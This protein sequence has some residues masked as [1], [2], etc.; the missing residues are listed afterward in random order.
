[1]KYY[2]RFADDIIKDRLKSSGAVLIEGTKGCGKTETAKQLAKSVARFDIDAQVKLQMELNPELVLEGAVPRLLDEWQY[3]PEI[4]NYVRHFIDERKDK[5]QFILT[6]SASPDE[7]TKRHSGAGRFSI[8]KMRPMSFYERGWSSGEVSLLDLFKG[9]EPITKPI[10][11][12]LGQ[13]AE[14]I[15]I[16]GWPGLINEDVNTGLQFSKDYMSLIAEIDLSKVSNRNRD[17]YKVMRLLQSYARNISTPA[18]MSTLAKDIK[19]KDGDLDNATVSSYIDALEKLM[20]IEHLPAWNTHIRSAHLLRTSPK[21]HFA[22]PSMAVG[23]LGLSVDDLIKDLGYFTFL[24]E[25]LVIRDLRIYSQ[26]SGANVF[27]YRDSG[28]LEVD[29]IVEYPDGTW[30]AFEVKLG[31]GAV[32]EAASGLIAFSQKIDTSKIKPPSV[33]GVI[34]ANGFAHK[35]KDGVYVIPLSVLTA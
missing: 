4:W 7:K 9:I 12:E 34:T 33:L 10:D 27:Y 32:E 25:S 19:G 6:G 2:K 5:G 20:A 1:M 31:I 14:Q 22:D 17:P 35:R 21:R 3:Y 29:A 8:I 24:F 26:V 18:S 13:L 28:E 23:V 15:I 30:G 11:F 16:G